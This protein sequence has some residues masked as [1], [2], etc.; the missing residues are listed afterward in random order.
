GPPSFIAGGGSGGQRG[1]MDRVIRAPPLGPAR[2]SS[3]GRC[4]RTIP[5][6]VA[7]VRLALRLRPIRGSCSGS[8]RRTAGL[9]KAARTALLVAHLV[10]ASLATTTRPGRDP[11]AG[12]WRAGRH[13]PGR[14][15]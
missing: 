5:R 11:A 7:L 13:E 1:A 12:T 14:Q 9:A 4:R 10:T 2:W 6:P 8:R 15:A 3:A